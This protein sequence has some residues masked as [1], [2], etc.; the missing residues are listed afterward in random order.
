M[1]RPELSERLGA[2]LLSTSPSDVGDADVVGGHDELDGSFEIDDDLT[3]AN[4]T[5][6]HPER[7]SRDPL[8]LP[9]LALNRHF[10][11]VQVTTARRAFLLLF[12]GAAHAIDEAG[13]VH[14]FTSWR[15]LPVRDTDDGL[16]IVGGSLRVPR[17]LHLRRYERVRRPT[18][19]LSRRNVMLRDAHQCQYCLKRPP[20]RDLNIDH[21]VPRSRGGVDSWENLV[22]ACRPCNLRKGRR[23]PEEASMRLLRPP[24]APRWSASMLLLLGRPEPFKEWEPFLKSA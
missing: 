6:L 10:H 8:T 12:G 16:P 20:V 1:P 14:D 4:P 3:L 7:R 22:T 17:V 19:R 9:V 2:S 11:P 18:V 23:T 5:L 21:V 24:T 13:E 15:R